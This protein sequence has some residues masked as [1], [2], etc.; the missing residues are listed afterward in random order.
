M[1]RRLALVA[2]VC[3]LLLVAAVW[4]LSYTTWGRTSLQP[5]TV[6]GFT[7]DDGEVWLSAGISDRRIS[8]GVQAASG[9][10]MESGPM[11]YYTVSWARGVRVPLWAVCTLIATAC[12]LLAYLERRARQ[13]HRSA[14]GCCIRCGYNLTGNVSGVCPECGERI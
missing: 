6:V 1:I 3:L 8:F 11:R 13:R 12:A 10:V 4:A 9:P 5:R 7:R 2:S 14:S